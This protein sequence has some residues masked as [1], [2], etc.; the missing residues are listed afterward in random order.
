MIADGMTFGQY[1][2]K[3]GGV[4][5]HVVADAKK[6]SMNLIPAK[7]FEYKVCG[8]GHGAIVKGEV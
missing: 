4:L 7:R 6:G 2:S 3:Q 1:L 5:A 8:A